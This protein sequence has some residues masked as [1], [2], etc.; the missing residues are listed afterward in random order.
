[1]NTRGFKDYNPPLYASIQAYHRNVALWL[2]RPE[3][4]ASML[5]ATSW[6]VLTGLGPMA[7]QGNLSPWEI[8]ARTIAIAGRTLSPCMLTDLVATF[9]AADTAALTTVAGEKSAEP[10]WSR[11]SEELV[12]RAIVG[13][14]GAA[15]RD[16]AL[17]HYD[18]YAS[19]E[20]PRL[21]P[22]AIRQ[23]ATRGAADGHRLLLA[24]LDSAA[25]DSA[26][27]RDQL[28]TGFR[29]LPPESI[30]VPVE[31]IAIRVVAER[32]Q[33]PDLSDPALVNDHATIT[34]RLRVDGSVLAAR[35]IR[36]IV[37]PTFNARGSI[38]ELN[39]LVGETMV[40]SGERLSVE[41]LV[42]E[43][44][45]D[46]VAQEFVRFV[47]THEGDP[48]TWLGSHTPA[49]EQSWRLWYRVEETR[50]HQYRA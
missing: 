45:L 38:V 2:T 23:R 44:E 41:L 18:A 36:D 17:D 7:F 30:P 11:L 46:E 15:L 13:G 16:L 50:E 40:Q 42:G 49:R 9:L 21:D 5:V 6:G 47:A 28:A 19:G 22:D 27:L 26:Y 24:T 43:W 12:N 37:I 29:A 1:M 20:R 3:Q 48:S 32:L 14:I 35:V 4:R 39:S 10:H 8:G 34:A 25:T 31:T 33:F